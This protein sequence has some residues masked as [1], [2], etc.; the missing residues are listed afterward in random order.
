MEGIMS[1]V[2]KEMKT[3]ADYAIKEAKERFRLELD[4]SEQ[5]ISK[6][7][8]ILD[9]IYWVFFNHTKGE[10]EDGAILNTAT[11]W[12]SYLGE[13]MRLKW[14]GTWILKGSDPL[15]SI[16]NNEFSPISLVY[17][18]IT[19]H[20][21]YSLENYLN[22]TKSIIYTSVINPQQSRYPSENISQLIKQIS[23]K[24]SIKP[25]IIDKHLL[26]TLA[27]IVGLLLITLASII[28]YKIIKA[29]SI[30]VIGSIASATSSNTN[31]PLEKTL[32]T[33]TPY[34]T[35][36]PTVTLVP[37]YTP[38]PTITPRASYT[39]YPTYTQIA[40][41]T[42]T[43]T[44]KPFVPT[45]SRAP[46]KSPTSVPYNPT[47]THIPS[48]ELPPPTATELPSPTATELPPPTAT[49]PEPV[50]IES[51]EIDP[52]TVPAGYN[53]TITFIVYFS[54]PGYGFDALIHPDYPGQSGCRGIDND[55]DSIAY[56]DG[57]S[58]LLPDSTKINVTFRSSV[59]DCIASYS[60]R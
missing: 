46:T 15:L 55:G 28:G 13:Y 25:V 26:F 32:V 37:T 51:C 23:N 59:G 53:V 22:E 20:P 47:A 35:N 9:Q 42:P 16:I 39:P 43:E 12:G 38:K 60:S 17:Q 4:F 44:Q 5:S 33:P 29:G 52:S 56:C 58:G 34:S 50:V 45:S 8:K 24:Q 54:V 40:T 19:S 41:L 1:D 6:L 7:E 48:T 36:T 57:S 21:E 18:M 3:T 14:G 10:W 49:E 2:Y 31:I 11:I 30:S 27:G